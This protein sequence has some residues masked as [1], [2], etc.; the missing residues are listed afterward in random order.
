MSTQ[1][2]TNPI[3]WLVKYFKEAKEEVAKI[4]WPSRN[5][6]VRYSIVVIVLCLVLAVFFAGFD[7]ILSFGLQKLIALKK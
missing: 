2:K 5:T 6:T 4:S 1:P 3:T 7:W